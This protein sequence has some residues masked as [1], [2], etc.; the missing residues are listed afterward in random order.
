MAAYITHLAVHRHGADEQKLQ[1]QGFKKINLNLNKGSGGEAA[2]LWCK[3]GR[4][5]APVTRLQMSFNVQMRV[6]LISA[7]YTKCDSPFFNAEEVDPIS[8]WSFQGSTEYDSPIVEMYYTADPES[9]AQMFSQGWEK[10]GCDLNRKLGGAWFLFCWLK[11]EK[12]NYICDVAATDSFTSDER[13]F[14]DGYIRLDEDARRGAGSAFVFLWYRQTTDLKRAIR[15]LKISANESEFQALQEKGYQPMGFNF[16]E[17]TQG[18]P[19]YLWHKRDGSN[20]PIKAVDLLLNMEAVEPFEKAG[21]TVIKN[22]LN[23]G[24]KGRTE[25]LCFHR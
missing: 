21:I 16:N 14:R 8:V 4:D 20:G 10:W 12:Q 15:D 11:R 7:G 19:M 3:K 22:N 9:E 5:E 17:W 2:Y 6:G 1:S 24:I 13:Y 25:L 23:T 18:T